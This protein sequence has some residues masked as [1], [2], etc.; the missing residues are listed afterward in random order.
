MKDKK[1]N[2]SPDIKINIP[3][4]RDLTEYE[5]EINSD[6][7]DLEKIS[8][9]LELKKKDSLVPSTTIKKE[10]MVSNPF[11][12]SDFASDFKGVRDMMVVTNE[13]VKKIMKEIPIDSSLLKPQMLMAIQGLMKVMNENGRLIVDM[14]KELDNMERREEKA[15][16]AEEKATVTNNFIFA[17]DTK[18]LNGAL[19]DFLKKKSEQDAEIISAEVVD[20]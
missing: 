17:G 3:E 13:S 11:S 1:D 7:L 15:L 2:Q 16:A 14:Y 19:N 18:G 4:I 12:K 10:S 6:C 8:N 9:E 5:P 20:G